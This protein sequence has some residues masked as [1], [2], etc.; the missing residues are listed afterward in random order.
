MVITGYCLKKDFL[1]KV[2]EK[3]LVVKNGI[4]FSMVIILGVG[5]VALV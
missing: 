1:L 2:L 3:L 4:W 5:L